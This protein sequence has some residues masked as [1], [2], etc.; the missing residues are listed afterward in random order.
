MVDAS[1]QKHAGK[2][3]AQRFRNAVMNALNLDLDDFETD[4]DATDCVLGLINSMMDNQP[5]IPKSAEAETVIVLRRPKLSQ[6]TVEQAEKTFGYMLDR[7]VQFERKNP[8]LELGWM[9]PDWPKQ[10]SDAIRRCLEENQY[11]DAMNYIMFAFAQGWPLNE[12]LVAPEAVAPSAARSWQYEFRNVKDSNDYSELVK[13]LHDALTQAA[14]GKGRERHANDLPF[15]QQPMNAISDLIDSPLGLVYQVCKKV[16][17]GVNLPTHDQRVRELLG[18]I[19][20]TAGI[21]IWLNRH[22]SNPPKE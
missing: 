20:Y 22:Q 16:V 9:Q 15:S 2:P 12:A 7:L 5:A 21:V 8:G 6:P 10:C 14:Y 17:E 4:D 19:N 11:I 3:S 13:V 18:V 1:K